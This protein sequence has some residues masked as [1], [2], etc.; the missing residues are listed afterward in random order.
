MARS[1]WTSV[2]SFAVAATLLAALALPSAASAGPR[3][4][5]PPPGGDD[6][7]VVAGAPAVAYAAPD[8]VHVARASKNGKSWQQL[9]G[10]IRH[11][12]GA[13]VFDVD[14]AVAPDGRPWVAWTETDARGIRQARVARYDGSL[15]REVVGGDRPINIDIPEDQPPLGAFAPKI[16]FYDGRAWVA[17][18]QDSRSDFVIGVRRLSADGSHW[19]VVPAPSVARPGDP[20]LVVSSAK[21]YLA[22]ADVLVPGIEVFRYDAASDRFSD[23]AFS[24]F[25]SIYDGASDVAGRPGVLASTDGALQVWVRGSGNTLDP[26]GSTLATDADGQDVAGRYATWIAADGT[27]HAAYLKDGSWRAV[28]L[29]SGASATFARLA[30]GRGGTWL[31]WRDSSGAHVV[32][33]A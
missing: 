10:A 9:G 33:I 27:L 19:D 28:K 4:L 18:V 11:S 31:L 2:R 24:P 13:P 12:A 15:W 25:G 32:R 7:E 21:L 20:E 3:T 17:Y 6:I 22:V 16:T 29:P 1:F 23:P 5:A 26:L 14:L 8:G 30:S